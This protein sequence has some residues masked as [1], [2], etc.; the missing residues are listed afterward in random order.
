MIKKP[1]CILI[2]I[3]IVAFPLGCAA[4]VNEGGGE[5]LLIVAI[6]YAPYDFAKEVTAGTGAEVKMLLKPG[7]ESHTFEPTPQDIIA[8]EK[9]DLLIYTGGESDSWAQKI[10]SGLSNK[11]LKTVVISEIEG[12][13][14]EHGEEG[15]EGHSH[16][17]PHYWTSLK[18]SRLIVSAI[19]Q[20]LEEIDPENAPAYRENASAYNQKLLEL[21]ERFEELIAGAPRDTIIVADRFPLK[22]FV[23]DYGLKYY[24]AFDGCAAES[25]VP[26]ATVALL[27]DKV[28]ELNV[29]VVFIIEL[30]NGNIAKT[31]TQGTNAKIKTFYTCHN[32]AAADFERGLSY[33][34]MM[35]ENYRSLGEALI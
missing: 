21:D 10:L 30:S 1:L 5:G 33:Y 29:P 28:R 34:D 9:C 3:L 25:E 18:N 6:A 12:I 26:A 20:S 22:H 2:I 16:E 7:T 13:C 17:D 27:S 15:H 35:S 11:S 31:I 19:A 4:C 8:L 14:E 24:S 23:E 32:V